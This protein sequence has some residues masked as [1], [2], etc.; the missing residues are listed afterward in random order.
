MSIRRRLLFTSAITLVITVL[1]SVLPHSYRTITAPGDDVAVFRYVAVKRLSSDNLVDSMIGLQLKLKLKR[2]VWQQAVLSVDLSVE[3]TG[4]NTKVWMG[5]LE[6]LLDL[7]FI[8]AENVN[9]V[10]VRFVDPYTM[11]GDGSANT[12]R[13][14]AAADV[15]RT[16]LWLS[17]DLSKLANSDPLED[18]LWKQRLRL[19]IS[20]NS[21]KTQESAGF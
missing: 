11:Q 9:R 6:R 19:I 2:V 10:L 16:D 18:I 5:D 21:S 4:N 3:E 1:L 14:I 17:T 7:A 8:K 20:G 13:V 15:R 12:S